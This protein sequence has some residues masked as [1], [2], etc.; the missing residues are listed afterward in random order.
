[1]TK[2]PEFYM[3]TKHLSVTPSFFIQ[4][5]T[6]LMYCIYSTY[7]IFCLI[8]FQMMFIIPL[9]VEIRNARISNH[10]CL[11]SDKNLEAFTKLKQS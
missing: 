6:I 11:M 3:R 2:E 8:P 7:F 1:M 4:E 10:S 9:H 5:T